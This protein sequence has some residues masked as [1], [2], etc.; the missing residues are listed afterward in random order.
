[1]VLVVLLDDA[2][3]TASDRALT[4]DEVAAARD[5][6]DIRPEAFALRLIG[7]DGTVKLSRA[8]AVPMAEIYTL[9]DGM[10]MRQREMQ[11]R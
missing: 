6:L 7:K 1:M 2:V 10:P 4:G 5:D 8:Q 9:I 11:D 3:S